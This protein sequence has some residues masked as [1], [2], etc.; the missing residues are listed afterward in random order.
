MLN[1]ESETWENTGLRLFSK[2]VIS[3]T[4][5]YLDIILDA[6]KMQI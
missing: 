5:K 6:L 1:T 3:R 2:N 4:E